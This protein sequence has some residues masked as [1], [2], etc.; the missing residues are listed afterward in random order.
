[1]RTADVVLLVVDASVGATATDEAVGRVLRR[2]GKPVVLAAN[3]VD[4]ERTEPEA[5]SLWSLGLGEPCPVSALHGRG[6]GDLLD[7]MLGRCPRRRRT[8]R[9]RAA[10]RAGSPWSAGRTSASPACS[11]G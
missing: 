1:M 4:D 10:A 6:A 7:A 3:K 8:G 5:A 9:R 2:G 11:T